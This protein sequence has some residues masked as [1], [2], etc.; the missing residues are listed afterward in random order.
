M[1]WR[2]CPRLRPLGALALACMLIVVSCADDAAPTDDS[3]SGGEGASEPALLLRPR[4]GETPDVTSGIPHVQLDQTSSDELLDQLVTQSFALEGVVEQPSQASRPGARALTV[5]PG[6]P[7]R[8]DA[9]IIGR[10][11]AHI[12]PQT[13]GGGSLHVRLTADH[14]ATVVDE[15]WGEY[16]PFAIDGTIPNL[17]M[18][19]A[20]RDDED[21]EVVMT[22]VG[23]AA[24]YATGTDDAP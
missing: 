18:V 24:T 16:H 7:A 10:E 4:P 12:H 14:A 8:T 15:G 23:A 5:A 6:L 19:Y 11:F 20:P 3:A 17:V 21:L 9:M 22:I 2:R 13:S 1:T